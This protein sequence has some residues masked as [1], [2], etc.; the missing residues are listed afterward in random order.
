MED[1]EDAQ[2]AWTKPATTF[3]IK[4]TKSIG[5]PSFSNISK[6][7]FTTT[8]NS[9]KR[10][11]PFGM[12]GD[13]NRGEASKRPRI[14]DTLG[15]RISELKPG[16]V[17][18]AGDSSHDSGLELS[19]PPGPDF[20][21]LRTPPLDWSLKARAPS[22]FASASLGDCG[23][24]PELLASFT[25]TPSL[26][27]DPIVRDLAW[28]NTEGFSVNLNLSNPTSNNSSLNMSAKSNRSNTSF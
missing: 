16:Q 4:R 21:G 10:M 19:S 9:V 22:A 17:N 2:D 12:V 6:Q 8:S 15:R 18:E 3:K 11:N 23:L 24:S 5:R 26:G 14:E 13:P 7:S 25:A 28:L 20:E 1:T 27:S